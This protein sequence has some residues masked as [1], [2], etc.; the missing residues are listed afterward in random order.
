MVRKLE[1]HKK[2]D[3]ELCSCD[4]NNRN[5]NGSNHTNI[6]YKNNSTTNTNNCNNMYKL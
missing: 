4:V 1:I 3:Q 2:V 5:H 6:K